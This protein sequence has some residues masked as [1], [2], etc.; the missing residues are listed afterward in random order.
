MAAKKREIA[1]VPIAF[2]KL[3]PLFGLRLDSPKVVQ[4]LA[5]HPGHTIGRPYVGDQYVAF[6]ASGL[7]FLF[8]AFPMVGEAQKSKHLRVLNT[9]FLYREGQDGYRGFRRPPFKI[10]WT[11]TRASMV[12]KLGP[13]P[14]TSPPSKPQ[15]L[16][17]AWRIEDFRVHAMFQPGDETLMA[18][19]ATLGAAHDAEQAER[20]RLLAGFG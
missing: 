17:A 8:R 9:V 15:L 1:A 5:D 6:K 19:S 4:F 20:V 18:L 16:W 13:P 10:H 3:R 11:D 14:E 12:A 2:K 7:S